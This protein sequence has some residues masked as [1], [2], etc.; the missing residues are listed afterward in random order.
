MFKIM[1]ANGRV[2]N[3]LRSA[4]TD[5]NTL[6]IDRATEKVKLLKRADIETGRT[7]TDTEFEAEKSKMIQEL[8]RTSRSTILQ[9]ASEFIK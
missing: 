7:M 5:I 2:F 8:S 9:K 4:F 1:Q 3:P 6:G